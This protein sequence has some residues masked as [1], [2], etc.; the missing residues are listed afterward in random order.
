MICNQVLSVVFRLWRQKY[1]TTF[2]CRTNCKV[3][4]VQNFS[5][6]WC[7]ASF[8]F[9][10]VYLQHRQ[11]FEEP[12]WT[13]DF[14]NLSSQT[15]NES[16]LTSTLHVWFLSIQILFCWVN[17]FERFS[18]QYTMNSSQNSQSSNEH[19]TSKFLCWREPT[20]II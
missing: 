1:H 15:L 19:N 6:L 12:S 16:S 13:P 4:V 18:Q 7:S 20:E 10:R 11:L 5:L 9:I 2:G 14:T 8:L 3:R 17:V